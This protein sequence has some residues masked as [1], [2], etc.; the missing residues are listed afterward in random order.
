MAM[1]WPWQYSFPPFFT[2]QPNSDTRQKQ[3]EAWCELVL[4]YYKSQKSYIL[5]INEA[6]DKP[7]FFNQEIK[8]E[9]FPGCCCPLCA[10]LY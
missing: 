3:L 6:Y 4:D 5:D 8:R 1:Q 10:L 9:F 7:L 2:I